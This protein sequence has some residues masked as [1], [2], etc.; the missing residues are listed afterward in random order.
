M[1]YKNSALDCDKLCVFLDAAKSSPAG[2]VPDVY[3]TRL[4]WISVNE[5]YVWMNS[6]HMN[7]NGQMKNQDPNNEGTVSLDWTF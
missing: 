6:L 4:Q 1:K 2:T 5:S 3:K 7:W